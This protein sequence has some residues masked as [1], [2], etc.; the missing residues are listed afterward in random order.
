MVKH[1]SISSQN[2]PHCGR[3]ML[4]WERRTILV[5]LVIHSQGEWQNEAGQGQRVPIEESR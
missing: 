1:K 5:R 3:F 4:I 2:Y